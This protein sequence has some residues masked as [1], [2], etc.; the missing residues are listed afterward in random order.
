M[1]LVVLSSLVAICGYN[2][3]GIVQ[4][5]IVTICAN[6]NYSLIRDKGCITSTPKPTVVASFPGRSCLQFLIAYCMQKRRGKAW[7]EESHA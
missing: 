7:G 4:L 2:C 5:A 6:T 3:C 1:P